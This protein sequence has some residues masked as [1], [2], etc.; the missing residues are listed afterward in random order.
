M[1]SF[2]L[3]CST[4]LRLPAQS[5][6]LAALLILSVCV[7]VQRGRVRFSFSPLF[8]FLLSHYFRAFFISVEHWTVHFDCTI[9]IWDGRYGYIRGCLVF[10]SNRN[11]NQ[12]IFL[13]NAFP[14]LI[15]NSFLWFIMRSNG[16]FYRTRILFIHNSPQFFSSFSRSHYSLSRSNAIISQR[17]SNISTD[18]FTYVCVSLRVH[19]IKW[20]GIEQKASLSLQKT[21]SDGLRRIAET[22]KFG[23]NGVAKIKES[24][25]ETKKHYSKM[26]QRTDRRSR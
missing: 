24:S 25:K 20:N 26:I 16:W 17:K 2:I 3:N 6:Q 22:K 12:P 14:L 1:L 9:E 18:I 19:L 10:V 21:S 8:A 7:L 11:C 13:F 23:K 4:L 15:W 5:A